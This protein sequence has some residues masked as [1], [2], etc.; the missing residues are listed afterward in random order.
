MHEASTK[1]L[2]LSGFLASYLPN[3]GGNAQLE[4]VYYFSAIATHLEQRRPGVT[5]RH[6]TYIECL[7]SSGIIPVLGRFKPRDVY[8]RQCRRSQIHYEEKETDVA[9]SVKLLEIL[10][11]DAADTVVLVTGDTDV[12]PAVRTAGRL[13]PE[14]RIWFL[15]PY[16]RKNKELAQIASGHCNIRKEAYAR[17]QFDDVVTL[18]SGRRLAKPSSW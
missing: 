3:I 10:H 9:I 1:W 18:K 5:N 16:K 8:C 11:D 6:R 13:F 7:K 15:F 2:D 17:H 14:K 4:A 12:A